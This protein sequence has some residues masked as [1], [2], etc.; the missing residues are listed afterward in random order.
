MTGG[1]ATQQKK[2]ISRRWMEDS[3]E[4]RTQGKYWKTYFSHISDPKG[5]G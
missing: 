2:N 1:G 5:I 3:E 4:A